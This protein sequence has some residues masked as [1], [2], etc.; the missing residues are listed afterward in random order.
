MLTAAARSFSRDK[1]LFLRVTVR[2][3][4]RKRCCN[5]LAEVICL[6]EDE[7]DNQE[8]YK[9]TIG[10]ILYTVHCTITNGHTTHTG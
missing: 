9:S 3:M 5:Q 1:N 2:V 7:G 10:F 8:F 6:L 4:L